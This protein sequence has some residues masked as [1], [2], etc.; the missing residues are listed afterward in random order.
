MSINNDGSIQSGGSINKQRDTGLK[1][2]IDVLNTVIT[3]IEITA[4]KGRKITDDATEAWSL[5]ALTRKAL[6]Q[7]IKDVKLEASELPDKLNRLSKTGWML[8]RLTT[9]YRL[10]GI[11]SA[12]ISKVNTNAALDKLHQ[13]N[14]RLFKEV[15]LE[16]G[17]AFLKVG[18]ILSARAD[19]LPEI[20]VRE[21]QVLQDHAKTE[22]FQDIRKMIQTELGGN[23]D[24][25]FVKFDSEPLAAASIGQ[26]HRAKLK[27]GTEVAV[28]IQRP[29]LESVIKMDMSLMKMFLKS[30]EAIMP[31]MDL[32]TITK[33]IERAISEELDYE[34]EAR[35]MTKVGEF[36]ADVD[37]VQVPNVIDEISTNNILVSEYIE[38]KKFTDALN[39][40]QEKGEALDTY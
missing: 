37:G 15:S 33:E 24:K 35:W 16:H 22:S 21:L 27:D 28:K 30:L 8:A 32:D 11:R 36:L 9:S 13:K 14:A 23:L 26:V 17:G 6:R 3:A 39:E 7:D 25:F 4:W 38:G 12:F 31:E 29:K 18:Q 5:M 40:H 34:Q 10:W 20:W 19:I 1:A 2:W